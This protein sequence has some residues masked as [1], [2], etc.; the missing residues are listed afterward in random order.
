MWIGAFFGTD[1]VVDT[2]SVSHPP[3]MPVTGDASKFS[4]NT[5]VDRRNPAPVNY[6]TSK[7]PTIYSVWYIPGG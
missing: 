4:F 5:T 1:D 6:G 3:R 7:Y 2:L